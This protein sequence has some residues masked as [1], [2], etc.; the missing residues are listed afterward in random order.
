VG[1]VQLSIDLHRRETLWWWK[2]LW[3]QR[4][5]TKGK[6]MVWSILENKLPTWDNLQNK[7][8][9]GLGWCS[10]CKREAEIVVHLFM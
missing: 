9:N 6:I 5:P 4:C 8:F 1:Y 10:L 2:K 7:Q 3:K